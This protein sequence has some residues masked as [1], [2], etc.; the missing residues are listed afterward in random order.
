MH[1][2]QSIYSFISFLT[3]QPQP[4]KIMRQDKIDLE[5]A[6]ELFIIVL[7]AGISHIQ[8]WY[9]FNND[10]PIFFSKK[11]AKFTGFRF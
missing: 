8:Q 7:N 1:S 4:S 2:S 5:V 6:N 3:T 9:H 11:G 10:F